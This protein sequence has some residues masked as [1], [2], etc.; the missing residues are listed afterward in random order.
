M[1]VNDVSRYRAGVALL[2]SDLEHG[3]ASLDLS[4]VHLTEQQRLTLLFGMG[5][6]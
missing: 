6:R 1:I 2:G 3:Y 4:S 5:T